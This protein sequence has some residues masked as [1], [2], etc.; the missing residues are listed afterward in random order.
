MSGL[1]RPTATGWPQLC[2]TSSL[3]NPRDVHNRTIAQSHTWTVD[4]TKAAHKQSVSCSSSLSYSTRT[5]AVVVSYSEYVLVTQ[6]PQK[7]GRFFDS[8]G[9]LQTHL[10][11][12]VYM[13]R[14]MLIMLMMKAMAMTMFSSVWKVLSQQSRLGSSQQLLMV[15]IH[16]HFHNHTHLHPCT[17]T[18]SCTLTHSNTHTYT[19]AHQHIITLKTTFALTHKHTYTCPQSHC[20]WSYIHTYTLCHIANIHTFTLI[21]LRTNTFSSLL[22]PE[23]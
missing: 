22:S 20:L 7:F 3:S 16:L 1:V 4:Y 10:R 18:H 23:W 5:R 9:S 8:H 14:K 13:T 17:R 19:Y 21:F 6:I 15:P 12:M 11:T 2:A